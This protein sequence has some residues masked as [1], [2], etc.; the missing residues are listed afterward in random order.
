MEITDQGMKNLLGSSKVVAMVGLSP[1]DDKPS[2]VVA[3]YLKAHGYRVIPVNPLYEEIL[4]EKSYKSLSDIP[5]QVDIV[6]IFMRAEKVE[7]VVAEAITIKPRAIWL[8]LGIVNNE[9]RELAERNG[10]DFVQDH[11]IKIEHAR[12][13]K[14]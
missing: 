9:A 5:D 12:L 4:G 3:L 7:P 14:K 2:N 1:K 13:L 8:Q 6:D 11:C 10:I